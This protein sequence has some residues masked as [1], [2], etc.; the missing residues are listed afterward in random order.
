[1]LQYNNKLEKKKSALLLEHTQKQ[2]DKVSPLIF[3][4]IPFIPIV[5]LPFSLNIYLLFLYTHDTT[6]YYISFFRLYCDCSR[7]PHI[8]L[9]S[10]PIPIIPYNFNRFACSTNFFKSCTKVLLRHW[11]SFVCV[12]HL[13]LSWCKEDKNF[14]RKPYRLF[15]MMIII[16][17]CKSVYDIWRRVKVFSQWDRNT[18][19]FKLSTR[20][21]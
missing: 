21:G 3:Q 9:S 17:S 4:S 10:Y 20:F 19:S 8:F 12:Y 13:L 14:P 16:F 1:M 7:A 15:V 18:H 11:C 6:Q 2:D 5:S